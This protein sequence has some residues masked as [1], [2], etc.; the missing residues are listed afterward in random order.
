MLASLN[1]WLTDHQQM[2]VWLTALGTFGAVC[3]S[4]YMAF[5]NRGQLRALLKVMAL[6]TQISVHERAAQRLEKNGDIYPGARDRNG[7]WIVPAD[8]RALRRT[9]QGLRDTQTTIKDGATR[10]PGGV[11]ALPDADRERLRNIHL[12]IP[13][14]ETLVHLHQELERA[15]GIEA[16]DPD[17]DPA[18]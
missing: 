15:T 9:M 4:L 7:H 14:L 1:T 17:T 2:A 11:A 13:H 6:P 18:Q 16:V 12:L 8:K 5:R 3:F 10:L